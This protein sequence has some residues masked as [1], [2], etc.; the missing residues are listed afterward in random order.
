MLQFGDRRQEIVFIGVEYDEWRIREALDACL[1]DDNELDKY[2]A[3]LR[4]FKLTTFEQG[5]GGPSLFRED[6]GNVN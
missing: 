4:N 5:C 2:R 1:L 6:T 3:D